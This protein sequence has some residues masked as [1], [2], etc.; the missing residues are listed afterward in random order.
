MIINIRKSMVGIKKIIIFL[1]LVFFLPLPLFAGQVKGYYRS[2]GTYVSPHNRSNPNHTVRD[3]YSY[4]GNVN[5]Y[6][7]K[8][9]T[10]KYIDNQTS[11]YYIGN[12]TKYDNS[13]KPYKESSSNTKI[14]SNISYKNEQQSNDVS[15]PSSV[16]ESKPSENFKLVLLSGEI[17]K[18]A[19]DKIFENQDKYI[20]NRRFDSIESYFE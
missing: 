9:G 12:N 10:N 14:D 8:V 13:I 1:L 2:N 4:K 5:P 18:V 15:N 3:N 19:F 7:G 16:K 6:T 11:E 20:L 17:E